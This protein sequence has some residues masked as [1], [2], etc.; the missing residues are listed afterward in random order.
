MTALSPRAIVD[1][2]FVLASSMA[3]IRRLARLYGGRPGFLGFVTLARHVMGHLAVTGGMAAGDSI[4]HELVGKGIATRISAKLGEGVVNG[5]MTA[6]V[7]L[8]AIDVCRPLP[9]VATNGCASPTSS[10]T[11]APSRRA[12]GTER[13]ERHRSMNLEP[14]SRAETGHVSP[15]LRAFS[16]WGEGA[17]KGRMRGYDFYIR[18]L[19][20][21]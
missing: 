6:R 17:P 20:E 16:R 9:F 15:A 10:P 21:G 12:S 2:L 19:Y 7:G 3:L 1:L 14:P 18:V 13:G 11:S 8:A 5:L 4:L